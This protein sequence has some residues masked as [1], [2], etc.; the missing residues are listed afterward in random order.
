MV[1]LSRRWWGCDV[2]DAIVAG[3][4]VSEVAVVAVVAI[5]GDASHGIEKKL[6]KKP[7]SLCA[8]RCG[9]LTS[10][11]LV[12]RKGETLVLW[13][14]STNFPKFTLTLSYAQLKA[15]RTV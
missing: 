1:A 3:V 2:V 4:A 7:Q 8:E 15:Y 13:S 12:R 9:I 5:V 6:W 14:Q 11:Q 10:F